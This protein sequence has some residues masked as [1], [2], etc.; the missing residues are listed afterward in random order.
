VGKQDRRTA[1]SEKEIRVTLR[2]VTQT[3]LLLEDSGERLGI[4][5]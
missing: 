3:P 4:I 5:K 1:L 2:T